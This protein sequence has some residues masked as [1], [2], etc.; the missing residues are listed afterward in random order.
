[1]F[2]GFPGGNKQED[3]A[4]VRYLNL[5]LAAKKIVD[6]ETWIQPLTAADLRR[7]LMHVSRRLSGVDE[8]ANTKQPMV[9]LFAGTDRA[10]LHVFTSKLV[11][12]VRNYSEFFVVKHDCDIQLNR[13]DFEKTLFSKLRLAPDARR[14]LLLNE[15]DRLS[16]STPLVLHSLAD[17]ESSPFKGIVI[18]ATLT[19]P[20][21]LPYTKLSSSDCTKLISR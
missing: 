18:F 5:N 20:D 13:M 6:E 14:F 11:K 7:S 17:N 2:V 9:L 15:I 16:D 19:L 3:L 10:Q 1:L 12:M 21:K 4:K 8:H